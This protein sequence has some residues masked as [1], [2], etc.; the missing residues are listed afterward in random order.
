MPRSSTVVVVDY[1]MGNLRSVAQ[2][3]REAARKVGG[4]Y[5]VSVSSDPETVRKA[6]RVV[7]PGQGAMPDCMR[8]LKASGLQ[9]A[10]LEAIKTKP[11]LG[12]CV[13]MQMLLSMS[14]EGPTPGLDA[15]AGEVRRFSLAGRK[16]SD[17]SP[18]KVPQMGWNRVRQAQK[19]ALWASIADEARFYF[20]HSFAAYPADALHTA[21][22]TDFGGDFASALARDNIFATQFH[23]EKSA[24][25]GLQLYQ[26][27]LRWK[28]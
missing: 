15:I 28:P 1:G 16:Q 21:G 22:L 8:E 24:R 6:D 25:D 11:L 26:N 10:V 2:A 7:L 9:E 3:A 5:Q 13:G 23:P 12:T 17:G 19:H 27:F 20:V 4:D 14:E 18:F